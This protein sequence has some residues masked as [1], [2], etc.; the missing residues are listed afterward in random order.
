MQIIFVLHSLWRWVVLLLALAA[1]LQALLG[2]LR[3]QPWTNLDNRLG[4]AFTTA[5]DIQVVLGLIVYLGALTGSHIQRW[6]TDGPGQTF[7][8][9][10]L[11][12]LV[13]LAIAHIA[14]SRAKKAETALSKHRTTAIGFILAL[15]LVVVSIPSW[16][17][18][19]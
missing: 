4:L 18:R 5:F 11:L 8:D 16:G 15:L 14:R 6:Y 17:F 12:M 9:H 1:I 7:T 2:W 3:Q 10:I 13:A 19:F